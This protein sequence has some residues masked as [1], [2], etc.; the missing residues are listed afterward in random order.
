MLAL[1]AGGTGFIGSHIV[2]DLI[3]NGIQVRVLARKKSDVD[4]LKKKGVEIVY[5]NVLNTDCLKGCAKDVDFVFSAFG[6]L[7]QWHVSERLY[8]EINIEGVKNLIQG[9]L[10]SGIK[11]F[12]HISSAGVLGPLPKGVV[13]D[14]SFPLN[15]SNIYEE[16]KCEA[17]K[18]ILKYGNSHSFPFT[19]IRPEFV[20]GPGDKHVL[21]LFKAVLTKRFLLLGNGKSLLHPTYIEDLIR[22]INLCINNDNALRQIFLMTGEKPLSVKDLTK[23][24]A[25]ELGVSL[26]KMKIPLIFAYMVANFS[27]VGAKTFGFSP[28]LTK[29]RVKFFSENRAFSYK[30]AQSELGYLPKVDFREGVRRTVQWYREHGF[31]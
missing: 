1:V 24:M 19:I 11:Q 25:E 8:H 4:S 26:S 29:S 3:S 7:G 13:A 30:K 22:G 21:G 17:E 10:S 28:M 6:L 15:P 5:G 31:L 12:I 2:S 20:Y 27:E 16:T 14:E 23:T 9:C 18:E